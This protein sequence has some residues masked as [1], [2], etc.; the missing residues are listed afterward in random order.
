MHATR[1]EPH[2]KKRNPGTG[3]VSYGGVPKRGT[4]FPGSEAHVPV[5]L[6]RKAQ[7]SSIYRTIWS[8]AC[9]C[10]CVCV[11]AHDANVG[12]HLHRI[13]SHYNLYSTLFIFLTDT[14]FHPLFSG[15]HSWLGDTGCIVGHSN[16]RGISERI[17]YWYPFVGNGNGNGAGSNVSSVRTRS[18]QP[19]TG[20]E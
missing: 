5:S 9:L 7:C 20:A 8:L 14:R 16:K 4:A 13:A 15:S 1:V 19:T 10:L 17:L 11:Y 12:S 6:I 3:L 18:S 2:E